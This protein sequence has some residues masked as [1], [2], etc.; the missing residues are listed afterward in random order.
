MGKTMAFSVFHF[1]HKNGLE[2]NLEGMVQKIIC[3]LAPTRDQMD[4]FEVKNG[5][6]AIE[7]YKTQSFINIEGRF[8]KSM[9]TKLFLL[10]R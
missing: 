9:F 4:F 10:T 8:K 7:L 5:F 3:S 2:S 1:N 6:R